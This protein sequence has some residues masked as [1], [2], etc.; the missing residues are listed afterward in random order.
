MVDGSFSSLH[1][2]ARA[3]HS[4]ASGVVHRI[5]FDPLAPQKLALEL[6]PEAEPVTYTNGVRGIFRHLKVVNLRPW[7]P[8]ATVSGDASRI[9]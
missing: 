1:S 6:D 9:K 4:D 3:W 2:T 8:R 7:T 5:R